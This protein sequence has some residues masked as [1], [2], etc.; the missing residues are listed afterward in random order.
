[1]DAVKGNV[2]RNPELILK[3]RDA[4]RSCGLSELVE[5]LEK[6]MLIA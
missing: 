5:E 1:M 4:F 3:L 6:R 2:E